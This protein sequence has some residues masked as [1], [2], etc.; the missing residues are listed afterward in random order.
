MMQVV[1]V[2]LSC[3]V[4][5]D[6]GRLLHTCASESSRGSSLRDLLCFRKPSGVCRQG[7]AHQKT[8]LGEYTLRSHNTVTAFKRF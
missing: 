1:V 6:V 5:L 7:E 2:R 3:D 8:G 4:C